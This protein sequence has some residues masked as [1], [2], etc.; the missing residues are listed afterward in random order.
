VVQVV[1]HLPRNCDTLSSSH[2]TAK[3]EKH[4][5]FSRDISKGIHVTLYP[6]YLQEGAKEKRHLKTK[7]EGKWRPVTS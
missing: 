6:G 3:K 4:T 5:T 1:E 7:T 2:S